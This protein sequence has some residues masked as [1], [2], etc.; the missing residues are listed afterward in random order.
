LADESITAKSF[1]E[2]VGEWVEVFMHRS[3]RDF[4]RFM[5][6]AGLSPTQV[7]AL[8]R[9]YHGKLCGVSDIGGHLGITNA[10]ASMMVDRLVQMGLLERSKDRKDRRLRYLKLT[11]PGR[12]LV[13]RGIE[14]RVAWMQSLTAN[15]SP[16]QQ[17]MI[18]EALSMLTEAAR[19]SEA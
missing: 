7:N 1:S 18:V 4:K 10:A 2:V 5:D 15:L 14:A 9:L 12:A 16:E 6:E 3:F 17:A 13:E 19:K 11:E 8:M